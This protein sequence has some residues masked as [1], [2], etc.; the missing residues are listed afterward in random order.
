VVAEIVRLDIAIADHANAGPGRGAGA[1]QSELPQW[2][3]RR[4]VRH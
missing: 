1:K 2:S 3:R 4:L